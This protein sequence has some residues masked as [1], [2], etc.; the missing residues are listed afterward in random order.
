[1]TADRYAHNSTFRERT[2]RMKR[3]ALRNRGKR[4]SMFKLTPD[5][6]AQWKWM[7]ERRPQSC[8]VCGHPT[9]SRCHLIS[10]SHG[11]LVNGNIVWLC[12]PHLQIGLGP[13]EGFS[14]GCH[15]RQEKRTL[16]F[17]A[18][19][20]AEGNPVNLFAKAAGHTAQWR[21]ETGR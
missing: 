14:T 9:Y 10:R 19:M 20:E 17:M 7:G 2:K 13:P 1:M 6:K 8:D 4:G 12:E 11:G 3:S 21:E 5:D 18:E 16:A 15:A